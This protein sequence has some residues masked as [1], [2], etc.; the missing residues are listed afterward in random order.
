MA[1]R[2]PKGCVTAKII[3]ELWESDKENPKSTPSL[4]KYL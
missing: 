3:A 2:R 4:K 1:N